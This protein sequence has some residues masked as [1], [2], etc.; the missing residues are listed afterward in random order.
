MGESS[1]IANLAT[2]CNN[3]SYKYQKPIYHTEYDEDAAKYVA[4]RE[5]MT[6]LMNADQAE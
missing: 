5:A 4:L 2:Y 1:V 6:E 3:M